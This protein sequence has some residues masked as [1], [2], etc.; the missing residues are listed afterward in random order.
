MAGHDVRGMKVVLIGAEGVARPIAFALAEYRASVITLLN[1]SI[2]KSRDLV[3][4]LRT[5]FVDTVFSNLAIRANTPANQY[6]LRSGGID[7]N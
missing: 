1:R 4:A 6:S 2:E 7:A 5:L 3:D